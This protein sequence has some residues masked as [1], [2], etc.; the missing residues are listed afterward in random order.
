[1]LVRGAISFVGTIMYDI[2]HVCVYIYIY[3][4]VCVRACMYAYTCICVFIFFC[5][6]LHDCM[7][8]MHACVYA[9]VCVACTAVCRSDRMFARQTCST[10]H[11]TT[12]KRGCQTCPLRSTVCGRFDVCVHAR[13][14]E[15]VDEKCM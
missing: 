3:L 12:P 13:V 10:I 9:F 2:I 11:H 4:F 14:S 5:I 8:Y 15:G 6:R 1:M 7:V